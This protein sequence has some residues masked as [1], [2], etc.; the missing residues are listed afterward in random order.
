MQLFSIGRLYIGI[1][2]YPQ[3]DVLVH[4]WKIRVEWD[5]SASNSR[6]SASQSVHKCTD[7]S[8]LPRNQ[9]DSGA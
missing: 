5:S 8:D 3:F 6:G 2:D 9:S 4:L 1:D 7:G